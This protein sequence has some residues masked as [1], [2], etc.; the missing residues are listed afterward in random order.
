MCSDG[1]KRENGLDNTSNF[2]VGRLS[3]LDVNFGMLLLCTKFW[4]ETSPP[5]CR[6]MLAFQPANVTYHLQIDQEL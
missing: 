3:A 5:L 1:I 2:R 6:S 4:P